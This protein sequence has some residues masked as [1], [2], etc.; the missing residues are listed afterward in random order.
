MFKCGKRVLALILSLWSLHVEGSRAIWDQPL[1][2]GN[3]YLKGRISTVDLLILTS[4][5]QLLLILKLYFS[6]LQNN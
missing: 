5:Y 3:P 2:P 1:G 6:F 4:S